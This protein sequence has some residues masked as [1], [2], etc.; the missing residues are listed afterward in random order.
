MS[1][2][3]ITVLSDSDNQFVTRSDKSKLANVP[4]NTNQELQNK[5]SDVQVYRINNTTHTETLLGGIKT[6]KIND[7]GANITVNDTV[8]ILECTGQADPNSVLYKS[9]Y[10]PIADASPG[11]SGYVDKALFADAINTTGIDVAQYYGSDGNYP[12]TEVGWHDLPVYVS[13]TDTQ[14]SSYVSIDDVILQ[15][16]ARSVALKHLANSR[17]V[18]G[19]GD[20]ENDLGD[21]V[22]NLVK[23]HYHKVYNSGT[24]GPY[25]ADPNNPGSYIQDTSAIEYTYKVPYGGM[26]EHAYYFEYNNN[27]YTFNTTNLGTIPV[28]TILTYVPADGTVEVT[29]GGT[30]RTLTISQVQPSAV[31]ESYFIEFVAQTD[32]SKINKWNFGNNLS[33]TVAD[34]IATINAFNAGGD[35]PVHAFVN[36]DDVDFVYQDASPGQMLVVNETGN[37]ITVSN[38]PTLSSY[39]LISD[40]VNTQQPTKVNA[41]VTADTATSAATAGSASLLQGSYSV[42]DSGTSATTLW[43]A[44][45]ISQYVSSAISTEGVRTD[46]GTELPTSHTFSF[47]PK[48]GDLYILID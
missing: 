4:A 41:A 25:I 45:K 34:G 27:N 38:A 3:N 21:N 15:P 7:Y 1:T 29:V 31:D 23:N 32:W 9:E 46:Y 44:N 28:N 30:L 40:Y 18:Y 5:I 20:E 2:D 11:K 6:L 43:S 42:N 24:Q 33:V 36:L 16:E 26:V 39:M 37:G 47:T 10:T 48:R 13:T 8:G 14:P 35:T 17:T 22:Y 19:S 12:T